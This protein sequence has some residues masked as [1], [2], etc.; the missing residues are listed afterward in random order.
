MRAASLRV[1][2]LRLEAGSSWVVGAN[3][4]KSSV[5]FTNLLSLTILYGS[6][7]K[8]RVLALVLDQRSM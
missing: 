7:F 1:P 4:D 8:G 3:E 2:P 6:P 5:K